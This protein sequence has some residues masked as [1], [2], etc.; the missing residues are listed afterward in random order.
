[1][2]SGGNPAF[3]THIFFVRTNDPATDMPSD[4]PH[5]GGS[6]PILDAGDGWLAVE[7]PAGMSVHND[8]DAD[9][10]SVVRAHIESAGHAGPRLNPD[11]AFGVSPVHRLD[12][13]TS[14]VLLLAC[15]GWVFRHF[16]EQFEAHSVEKRYLALLHGRLASPGEGGL[17][18]WKLAKGAAGRADPAG[19][20]P[21]S[22]SETR[23]SVLAVCGRYTLAACVPVTGR[24]HQIRRHARLAGHAVVGD[25]RYGSRRAAAYIAEHAG[26]T[27]LALHADT[28]TIRPP[29][30]PVPVV[31]KSNGLPP[32]IRRLMD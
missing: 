1:M 32:E 24:K 8:P 22:P 25:R 5:T 13:E 12:R 6:V 10:V 19:R 11:P 15:R 29:D 27:R 16:S 14:G 17:W 7:K 28:L 21:K 26:F 20:G 2:L 18:R 4:I 9:L 23:F 3:H 31:I 30:R